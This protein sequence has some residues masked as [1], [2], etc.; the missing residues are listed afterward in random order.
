MALSDSS[1]SCIKLQLTVNKVGTLCLPTQC[2]LRT[3][4]R[5]RT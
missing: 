2:M 1:E 4:T 5:A 3:E